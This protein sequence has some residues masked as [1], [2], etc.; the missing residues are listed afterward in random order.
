[1][2]NVFLAKITHPDAIIKQISRSTT[3][4][5]LLEEF[6]P[7]LK[8]GKI[9]IESYAPELI[10][11]LR[12]VIPADHPIGVCFVP[13]GDGGT[14][15]LDYETPLGILAPFLV[16][17]IAHALG[18]KLDRIEAETIA[19]QTQS[20]F[21]QELRDRDPEYDSFLKSHYPKAKHLLKLLDFEEMEEKTGK[22]A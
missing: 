21:A 13:E 5:K 6:L 4:R 16:H 11:R 22:R 10:A 19:I 18:K 15:F 20:L 7:L 3:G 1:M 2:P 12:E 14:I 8:K 9:H 17:E